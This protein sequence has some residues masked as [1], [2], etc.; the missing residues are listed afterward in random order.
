MLEIDLIPMKF[1][2]NYIEPNSCYS[3]KIFQ[4]KVYIIH[5]FAS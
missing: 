1:G 5:Y 2:T 3:R 4:Q